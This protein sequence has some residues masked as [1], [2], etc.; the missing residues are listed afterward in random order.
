LGQMAVDDPIRPC[1]VTSVSKEVINEP[2]LEQDQIT[3]VPAR[4]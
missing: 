2:T 3:E 1:C 4:C